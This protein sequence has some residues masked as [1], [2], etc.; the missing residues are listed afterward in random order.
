MEI[1]ALSHLTF[2]YP[3][4]SEPTLRDI[5]FSLHR[6]EFAVLCGAT[7]SGK[8]TLLRMLKRE[9]TPLGERT[10]EV[11][12]DGTSLAKLDAHTAAAAI[13]FVM[14]KPE[15]QIVTDKV[16]HE[17]AFGLENLHIPH[18]EMQRRIAETASYFGIGQWYH[19][20]TAGLSGG[21]KQLLNLASVLVMQ[22][23]LL[24]LDEPTAQL[25][26]I[27]AS[28]FIRMLHRL[29]EDFGLTIL[30]TEHRT[31]EAVPLCDRLLVME[32]G[33]L[34]AD[35]APQETIT[36][37]RSCPEI[38]CGMPAAARLFTELGGSS[39]CPLTVRDGRQ[40]IESHYGNHIRSLPESPHQPDSKPALELHDVWFRYERGGE[41]ILRGM[42]L[43]VRTGEIF[44]LLGGNGS[45]KSTTL[46]VCAG[47]HR[48]YSGSIRIFGKPLRSYK[49]Q[50][51]YREC[52]ALLPQDVQTVF[53][54]ETVRAELAA[55]GAA[56]PPFDMTALLDRHPYD[57]SGGEQQIAALA[58]V[59]AAK[60]RLLLLDEPTKGMDAAMK[61]HMI[62]ILHDLREQG[63]TIVIV[64]HD[65]EFAAACADRCAMCF[66]G[67]IAAA[68][69]PV[70]F[71]SGNSFYT[72]AVSR[73][74]RGWFDGA[75][76][77]GQA[78]ALC[79]ANGKKEDASC[80]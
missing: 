72:T 64:T 57:L 45:G 59:L 53:L 22:P 68:G 62:R 16:W 34:I 27:A 19:R 29:C 47:L 10:G 52:L 60:P 65:I 26:P 75:V 40:F 2:T 18:A 25:D 41:D 21:Q 44:C 28:E 7:G 23:Q 15:Q 54:M 33:A 70:A 13:G 56:E 61:Q 4:C 31:E 78:A 3:A 35:G 77:V 14:Q 6:G 32:R 43:T 17:L 24:I 51:L 5:S 73:M 8:T 58:R 39:V 46:A 80:L 36:A 74:T 48:P 66:D 9:L 50:S 67:S 37:L 42:E 38:L 79:R 55:C 63:V 76:T 69:D 71:F 12:F 20:D 11:C 1:L 49:N 30:M